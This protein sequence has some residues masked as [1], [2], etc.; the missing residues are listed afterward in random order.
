MKVIGTQGTHIQGKSTA[1]AGTRIFSASRTLTAAESNGGAYYPMIVFTIPSTEFP[2]F[3]FTVE[4]IYTM[5]QNV[6]AA[7]NALRATWVGKRKYKGYCYWNSISDRGFVDNNYEGQWAD[8]NFFGFVNIFNGPNTGDFQICVSS[9]INQNTTAS[10]IAEVYCN[11]WD[12]VTVSYV[13]S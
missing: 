13:T 9:S 6:F 7:G 3:L 5:H 4:Y 8:S 12:L 11:R 10:V 2:D 1:N